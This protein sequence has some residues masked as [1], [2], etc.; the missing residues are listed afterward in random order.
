MSQRLGLKI[1]PKNSKAFFGPFP[2]DHPYTQ[3][4][5]KAVKALDTHQL[6]ANYRKLR[7]TRDIYDALKRLALEPRARTLYAKDKNA[8]IAPHLDLRPAER[9]ALLSGRAFVVNA[10]MKASPADEADRFVQ[11]L[12][13]DPGFSKKWAVEI[14]KYPGDHPET[15]D[16]EINAW[17]FENG[18]D[19]SRDDVLAAWERMKSRPL[20]FYAGIY[21]TQV[22]KEVGP[23]LTITSGGVVY[24]GAT[25]IKPFIFNSNKLSWSQSKT[26][27]NT[28]AFEFKMLIDDKGKPPPKGT[29]VGPYFSGTIQTNDIT[30]NVRGRV[31]DFPPTD[32]SDNDPPPNAGTK[33]SQYNSTYS[34]AILNSAGKWEWTKD[35]FVVDDP[36][37]TY[38]GKAVHDYT[39]NNSAFNALT[40]NHNDWNISV[41]FY[42]S[43]SAKSPGVHFYGKRWAADEP[44][45]AKPNFLGQIG[46]S[47][48]AGKDAVNAYHSTFGLQIAMGLVNAV[49]SAV[50]FA[51]VTKA[52]EKITKWWKERTPEAE[53][54][55]NQAQEELANQN[56]VQDEIEALEGDVVDEEINIDDIPQPPEPPIE[57][58]A[59]EEQMDVTDEITEVADE[60]AEVADEVT[61]VTE[62]TEVAEAEIIVL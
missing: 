47:S 34:T 13:R 24:W 39:F 6:P 32:P 4:A 44:V 59:V 58:E 33:F 49:I 40:K 62:V 45:P 3:Q 31:G 25:K 46:V 48:D 8:F 43:T 14:K 19:I 29:Y 36:T 9:R 50:V 5:L 10:S 26:N 20:N 55:M 11:K 22:D 61:E 27:P 2:T 15:A 7:A 52:I 28:V 35:E 56:D 23:T 57:V 51:A 12:L 37:A 41:F 53:Q 60:V 30:K 1:P 21:N 18:F 38:Q 54:E 17:L 42:T 16:K